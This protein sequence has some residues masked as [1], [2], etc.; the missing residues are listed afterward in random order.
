VFALTNFPTLCDGIVTMTSSNS[1]S[2][3]PTVMEGLDP[4]TG[5]AT[6]QLQLKG[7]VDEF[8]PTPTVLRIDDNTLLL[9]TPEGIAT[10]DLRTG[11]RPASETD[12]VGWCQPDFNAHDRI[13]TQGNIKDYL[14]SGGHFPCNLGGTP[15]DQPPR[16]PIPDFAGVH[17]ARYSA[18][19]VDS[20]VLA[21][22][23]R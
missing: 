9:T 16:L 7:A 15:V 3:K 13:T 14:R 5:S 6:W 17:N 11:P 22:R 10:V 1:G 21:Q 8:N 4:I 19:V 12:S 18:W 23:N 2:S 20:K